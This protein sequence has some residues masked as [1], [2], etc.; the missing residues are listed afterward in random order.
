MIKKKLG[1]KIKGS[2]FKFSSSKYIKIRVPNIQISS[3][4]FSKF[5]HQCK[6]KKKYIWTTDLTFGSQCDKSNKI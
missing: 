5:V 3:T 2:I 4:K 6:K 1:I